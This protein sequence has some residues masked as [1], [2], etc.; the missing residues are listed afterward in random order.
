MISTASLCSRYI[1]KQND[2]VAI[3]IFFGFMQSMLLGSDST[4]G[5]LTSAISS[6][7]NNLHVLRKAQQELDLVIGTDRL[8]DDSDINNLSLISRQ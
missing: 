2:H 6:L 1:S 8:V 4:S 7:M 5:T 3:T